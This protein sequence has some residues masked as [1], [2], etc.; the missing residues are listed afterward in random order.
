MGRIEIILLSA[1]VASCMI[2]AY[3]EFWKLVVNK[4]DEDE[5]REIFIK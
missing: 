1:V 5:E 4:P 3:H 2:F